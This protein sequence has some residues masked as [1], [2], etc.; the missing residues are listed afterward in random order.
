MASL[1]ESCWKIEKCTQSNVLIVVK[2]LRCLFNQKKIAQYITENVCQ[3][4]EN[5][6]LEVFKKKLFKVIKFSLAFFIFLQSQ[7]YE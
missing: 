5:L 7:N 1:G 2:T 3:N 6:A 4:T